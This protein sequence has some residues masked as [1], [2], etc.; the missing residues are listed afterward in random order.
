MIQLLLESFVCSFK[1]HK[2]R[3]AEPSLTLSGNVLSFREK[4]SD[5]YVGKAIVYP[6]VGEWKYV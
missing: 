4:R 6:P 2:I 1:T 3:K 5:L